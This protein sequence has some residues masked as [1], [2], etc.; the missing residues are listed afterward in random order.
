MSTEPAPPFKESKDVK[1]LERIYNDTTLSMFTRYRALFSLRDL[2][3]EEAVRIIAQGLYND[4]NSALFK[5]EVAFVMGQLGE[6]ARCS[7]QA[8]IDVR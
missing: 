4:A 3:T 2:G 5:H 6:K 7:L 8:L 1:E